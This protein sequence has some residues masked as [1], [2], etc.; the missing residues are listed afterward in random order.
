[1]GLSTELSHPHLPEKSS[2]PDNRTVEK[3]APSKSLPNKAVHSGVLRAVLLI[4]TEKLGNPQTQ[5]SQ[6]KGPGS[7][8][9][10]ALPQDRVPSTAGQKTGQKTGGAG[11]LSEGPGHAPQLRTC[12]TARTFV[13]AEQGCG[14]PATRRCAGA[15]RRGHQQGTRELGASAH[16]NKAWQAK[17]LKTEYSLEFLFSEMFA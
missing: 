17:T 13:R 3:N 4:R 15:G 7:R 16:T 6:D 5:M 12:A 1:M 2:L 10:S 9:T 11:R 14:R 8:C